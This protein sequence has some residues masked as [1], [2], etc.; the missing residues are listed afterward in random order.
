MVQ[1]DTSKS[2]PIAAVAQESQM[3]LLE[4]AAPVGALGAQPK[5]W[6]RSHM[7]KEPG[8]KIDLKA[9]T[10]ARHQ[11]PPQTALSARGRLFAIADSTRLY[12]YRGSLYGS[13]THSSIHLPPCDVTLAGSGIGIRTAALR[14]ENRMCR[15]SWFLDP[16]GWNKTAAVS[17]YFIFPGICTLSLMQ[18]QLSEEA[19]R[20]DSIRCLCVR[21]G[22][23]AGLLPPLAGAGAIYSSFSWRPS[24]HIRHVNKNWSRLWRKDA[25]RRLS[26]RN[27]FPD[28][29]LLKSSVPLGCGRYLVIVFSYQCHGLFPQGQ[30]GTPFS[31]DLSMPC[32]SCF[33]SGFLIFERKD[34]M[35]TSFRTEYSMVFHSLQIIQL[36]VSVFVPLYHRRKLL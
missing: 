3:E 22:M 26:S 25:C 16:G 15:L 11:T 36:W 10:E 24:E 32:A 14:T 2:P 7:E 30:S 21:V 8:G 28:E 29:E 1:S 13:H 18:M 17:L 4:S 23:A 31:A 19:Y 27:A 6:V 33:S 9:Q 35:D 34:M 5:G 12:S 20:K